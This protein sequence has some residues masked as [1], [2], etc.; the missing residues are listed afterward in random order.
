MKVL[1]A[2]RRLNGQ[3]KND[4][5]EFKGEGEIV[6]PVPHL[7]IGEFA[8]DDDGN[9]RCMFGVLTGQRTT[10]AV[11]KNV[12]IV[13]STLLTDTA[14]W[15]RARYPDLAM[16]YEKQADKALRNVI[17]SVEHIGVGQIVECRDL[18]ILVRNLRQIV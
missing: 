16:N 6:V 17:Q 11:I 2:T 12:P 10:T 15:L 4:I 9:A 18:R 13:Y 8:D 14:N 1:V 5:F 7:N 3:R